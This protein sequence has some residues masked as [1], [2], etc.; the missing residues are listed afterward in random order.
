MRVARPDLFAALEPYWRFADPGGPPP[1]RGRP[2]SAWWTDVHA[3]LA[4]HRVTRAEL[5]A[6]LDASRPRMRA[7]AA[8]ALR[9]LLELRVPVTVVSAGLE[10]V[11]V[12]AG[13]PG[14]F[15]VSWPSR[16]SGVER[17]FLIQ[18]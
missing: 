1:L 17:L 16:T 9:A 13:A 11:I 7:G 15:W 6:A 8:D 12:A 14:L 3:L 2:F 5:A 18:L 4:Q 10:H